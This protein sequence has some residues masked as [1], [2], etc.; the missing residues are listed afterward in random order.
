MVVVFEVVAVSYVRSAS[1][2]AWRVR[3]GRVFVV[4]WVWV[5]VRL[6]SLVWV[7]E[8][9]PAAAAGAPVQRRVWERRGCG[10]GGGKRR[11]QQSTGSVERKGAVVYACSNSP[12][13]QQPTQWIHPGHS[14]LTTSSSC[15]C[16][17]H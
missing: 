7:R 15:R 4:V 2:R 6:V 12:A 13:P 16:I 17:P 3:L 10:Q 14:D 11:I 9:G 8:E 1:R 5:L